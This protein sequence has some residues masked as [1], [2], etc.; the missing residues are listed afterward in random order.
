M[1]PCFFAMNEEMAFVYFINLGFSKMNFPPIS[2][3]Q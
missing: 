2:S 1:N 3:T